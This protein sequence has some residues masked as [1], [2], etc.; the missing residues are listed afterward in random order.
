MT[1]FQVVVLLLAA[2]L[3]VNVFWGKISNVVS[4]LFTK[5]QTEVKPSVTPDPV[6]V[7]PQDCEHEDC[8]DLVDV[9]SSWT[10]LKECCEK[11]NL[12]NAVQELERIFPLFVVKS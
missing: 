10:H 9:I 2:G 4:A 6:Q 5:K 11:Q 3:V 1:G 12:K 8:K 7:V